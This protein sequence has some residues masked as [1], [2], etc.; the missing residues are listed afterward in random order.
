MSIFSQKCK[1]LIFLSHQWSKVYLTNII[2]KRY[3]ITF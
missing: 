2:Y 1:G 3:D